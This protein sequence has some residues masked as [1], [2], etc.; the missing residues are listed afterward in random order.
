MEETVIGRALPLTG[1]YALAVQQSRRCWGFFHEAYCVTLVQA[2]HGGWRYRG[3][4]AEISPQ[5]LMLMEPGEVHTT[6]AVASPGDFT[7]LFFAPELV[8]E[9]LS[10]SKSNAHFRVLGTAQPE[11]VQG[12]ERARALLGSGAEEEETREELSVA[13][14]ELF[15]HSSEVPGQLPKVP[16]TR[17]R[18][19]ARL[20]R[21]RYSS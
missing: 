17:V 10:E 19:A 8:R 7:A 3:R 18:K 4:Q 1:S 16:T 21:E 9:I 13:L 11:L 14:A 5:S 15:R 12:F 6:T 2:G 20:L